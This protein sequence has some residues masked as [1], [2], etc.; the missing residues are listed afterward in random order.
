MVVG[1]AEL[2]AIRAFDERR[3]PAARV[4][5]SAGALDLHHIGA[6]IGENLPRPGAGQDARKLEDA[7]A[8]EWPGH[9]KLLSLLRHRQPKRVNQ[10]LRGYT[11]NCEGRYVMHLRSKQVV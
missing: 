2:A 11:G 4:V 3:S 8:G 7:N 5:A 6:E 1:G 9:V 10:Q